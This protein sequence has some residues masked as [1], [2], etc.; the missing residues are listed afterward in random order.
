MLRLMPSHPDDGGP[1]I[2]FTNGIRIV[3]RTVAPRP[4]IEHLVAY[5]E[6]RGGAMVVL[7]LDVT[8]RPVYRTTL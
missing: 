7:G 2:R 5:Q 4:A 8:C 1:R 6:E 3:D